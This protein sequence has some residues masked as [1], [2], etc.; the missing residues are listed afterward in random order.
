[1]WTQKVL[2]VYEQEVAYVGE[3]KAQRGY[4]IKSLIEIVNMIDEKI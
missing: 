3:E 1:M 2:R 4:A